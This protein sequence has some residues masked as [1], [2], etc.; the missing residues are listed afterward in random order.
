M[1]TF[2]RQHITMSDGLTLESSVKSFDGEQRIYS[3]DSAELGCR[4]RFAVYLPPKCNDN[5]RMPTL[6]WL[7]GLTCTETNFIE[8]AGAQR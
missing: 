7:S 4:M 6:Y 5:N 1:W 3:H 8:K 2:S